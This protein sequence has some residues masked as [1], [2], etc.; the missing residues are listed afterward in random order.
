MMSRFVELYS[1]MTGGG[2]IGADMLFETEG[3]YYRGD[4]SGAKE[5]CRRVYDIAFAGGQDLIC[6]GA[7]HILAEIAVFLA[8]VELFN[9]AY[10]YMCAAAALS[11]ENAAFCEKILELCRAG[12]SLHIGDNSATPEWILKDEQRGISENIRNWIHFLRVFHYSLNLDINNPDNLNQVLDMTAKTLKEIRGG[13]ILFR[14]LIALFQSAL[15]LAAGRRREAYETLAG[16]GEMLNK[17]EIYQF[18]GT[19]YYAILPIIDE[20]LSCLPKKTAAIAHRTKRQYA[21]GRGIIHNAVFQRQTRDS[22]TRRELEIAGLAAKGMRNKEIASELGISAETVRTHLAKVHQKL[23]ID[24]R[25][26]IAEKL[27]KWQSAE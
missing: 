24:R 11:Q 7:A 16:V 4:I 25:A 17:D 27:Q 2:G 13:F 5:Q 14:S 10:D 26:L 12:L 21:K 22:L 19:M 15:F 23:L 6:I 8:D 3:R 1:A 20:Y 18:Y 9:N